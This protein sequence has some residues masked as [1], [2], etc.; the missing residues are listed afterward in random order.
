MRSPRHRLPSAEGDRRPATSYT[1]AVV[2][3][4]VVAVARG[5]AGRAVA[6]SL[7]VTIALTTVLMEAKPF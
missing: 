2:L 1:V 7:C 5:R 6:L 4:V 3:H